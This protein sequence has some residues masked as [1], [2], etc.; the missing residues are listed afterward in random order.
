MN[1]KSKIQLISILLILC[2][3]VFVC[4]TLTQINIKGND[5]LSNNATLTAEIGVGVIIALI[6]LRITTL[7]EYKIDGK[8]SSVLDIVSER[9][10]IRIEKERQIYRS[11]LSSFKEIQEE[12]TAVLND[13][14]THGQ[15]KQYADKQA[16]KNQIILRCNRIKQF[17]DNGLG[18]P[19]KISPEFFNSNTLGMIK[20]IL[21]LCN[22]EPKFNEDNTTVDVSFCG[23]L[24][25]MINARIT[26]LNKKIGKET[27]SEQIQLQ[28]NTKDVSIKVYSDRKIYPLDSTIHVCA[29]LTPIIS[30]QKIIF[31]VLNAKR[32]PLLS[33]EIDP[34]HHNHLNLAEANIFQVCFKMNG[35]EWRVG[36]RYIVRV[37]HSSSYAENL[38][39]IDQRMPVI[40]SDQTAYLIGSEMILTVIDPDAD[41]DSKVAEFVG[42]RNNSKITIESK[43]GNIDEYRLRE[44]GNSTGIF[45][46]TIGFLKIR[47]NG[48]VVP[49]NINGNIIDK[50]QGK[51][52]D[53]GFIGGQ[54]GDEII[55]RYE[56]NANVISHSVIISN[57]GAT[58]EMDQKVYSP[59]DK[60]HLT[61][62]APDLS[63]NSDA[64][65]EIGQD[66]QSMIQIQTGADRLD[67]FKL[68]ET[69][70]DT[71][72]FT[73]ELQLIPINEKSSESN[74]PNISMLGCNKEDFI[75][76]VFTLF[77]DESVVKRASIRS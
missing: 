46:G 22:N 29:N 56:N 25:S 45:Q 6:V 60:I 49:Q 27:D 14:K 63:L 11:V 72:I 67:N 2:S 69:G 59:T 64:V 9:K 52:I 3:I 7:S 23:N 30:G 51:G 37:T 75:E 5:E 15:L 43:Y 66:S 50:I 34:K 19:R 4:L 33:Q 38:F 28:E 55:I 61:I 54:R 31:E 8:I 65:D 24:E 41:K 20:T 42:D 74:D 62:I 1:P 40:Q 17:A 35:D 57:F 76:I 73:G 26:E 32:I 58:V 21:N 13:A 39:L 10:K 36:S 12:I 48:T 18:D 70:S 44:T 71:G 77:E 68:V 47:K 16:S 53:D